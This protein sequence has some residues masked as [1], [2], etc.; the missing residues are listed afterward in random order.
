MVKEKIVFLVY[1]SGGHTEQAKRYAGA[2][3]N[4]KIIFVTLGPTPLNLENEV[5][6]FK[7]ADIRDRESYWKNIYISFFYAFTSIFQT[8]RVLKQYN[9]VGFISTGPG[10]SVLPALI[11]KLL[12]KKVVYFESWSRVSN[13]SIA[14]IL[15]YKISDIFFIQ[16]KSMNKHYSN[17]VFKG[18]L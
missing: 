11:C 5:N 16:H 8:L 1:G 17:G 9:I 13:P 3:E 15:M 4:K 18:R 14:G 6:H 10:I 7:C 2:D 12:K